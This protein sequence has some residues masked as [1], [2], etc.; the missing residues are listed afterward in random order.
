MKEP[1]GAAVKSSCWPWGSR[2]GK[3]EQDQVQHPQW[4]LHC[5]P[6]SW[7]GNTLAHPGQLVE[8]RYE[9]DC[10]RLSDVTVSC[11][12]LLRQITTW[13][14]RPLRS[15]IHRLLQIHHK[16]I[17]Y[18]RTQRYQRSCAFESGSGVFQTLLFCLFCSI[19]CQGVL[20]KRQ[21]HT[22]V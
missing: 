9:K 20:R 14:K 2:C 18:I 17:K 13:L 22:C 21:R 12:D 4:T 15:R 8:G 1:W 10:A 3:Q 7:P 19:V 5:T 6:T 11:A 16:I